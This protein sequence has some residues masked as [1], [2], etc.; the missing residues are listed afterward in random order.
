[1]VKSRK[2]NTETQYEAHQ[3]ALISVSLLEFSANSMTKIFVITVK[4][5]KPAT[6]CVRE[7][8]A[9]TM[10]SRHT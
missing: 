6:S 3:N 2:V 4:G 10:P 7:Q 8:H 5:L 1:M 9:T